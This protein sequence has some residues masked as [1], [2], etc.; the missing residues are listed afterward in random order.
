MSYKTGQILLVKPLQ[1]VCE[2][3]RSNVDK[4][5][6]VVV[7]SDDDEK[8]VTKPLDFDGHV[9]TFLKYSIEWGYGHRHRF[10]KL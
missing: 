10:T 7:V 5:Y 8:L 3:F 4:P 2:H 6:K 9:R 1:D